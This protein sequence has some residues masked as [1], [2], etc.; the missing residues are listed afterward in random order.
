MFVEGKA[1][2]QSYLAQKQ[3]QYR[4]RLVSTS[5]V[6]LAH[7]RELGSLVSGSTGEGVIGSCPMMI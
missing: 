3:L 2:H 7:T 1:T 5:L 6:S 4:A